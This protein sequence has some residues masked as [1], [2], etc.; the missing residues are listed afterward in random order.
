V[1]M[2]NELNKLLDQAEQ[3][4][5]VLVKQEDGSFGK[6]AFESEEA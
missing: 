5:N 2:V 6:Q 1:K 4:I 3:K